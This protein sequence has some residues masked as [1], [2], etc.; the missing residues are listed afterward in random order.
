LWSESDNE[1]DDSLPSP[2]PRLFSKSGDNSATESPT[3]AVVH[4]EAE[5]KEV[6]AVASIAAGFA[7]A[8]TASPV[9]AGYT[10]AVAASPVQSLHD[11]S[12]NKLQADLHFVC[13][14]EAKQESLPTS[15]V[16][17]EG[18][19][20]TFLSASVRLS[21]PKKPISVAISHETNTSV[22]KGQENPYDD[23]CLLTLP[24]CT[25]GSKH[26]AIDQSMLNVENGFMNKGT[27]QQNLEEPETPVHNSLL[28]INSSFGFSVS[29]F[30]GNDT[31][32]G[33][34]VFLGGR[35]SNDATVAFGGIYPPM[36]GARTSSRI[37]LQENAD[38]TQM[39]RAQKLAEAKDVVS[40]LC[41]SL[42]KDK[43]LAAGTP[44]PS[45]FSLCSISDDIIISR[46]E[47]IGVPLGSS[48]SMVTKLVKNI[49]GSEN[50]RTLIMLSKNLAENI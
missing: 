22:R 39:E 40:S 16:I 34:G 50:T 13:T 49:K 38:D 29:K 17:S 45:K 31:R 5:E 7:A 8:A 3:S 46:A 37:R 21:S 14:K 33:T 9:R 43:G 32:N 6:A 41:T 11:M 25:D 28:N 18:L 24:L 48:P 42:T 35:L 26:D 4:S 36:K 1:V 44:Q 10:A 23:A 27:N 47:K 19:C 2:L 30:Q 20:N 12:V 15:I